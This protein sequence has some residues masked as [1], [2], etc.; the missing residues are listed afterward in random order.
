MPSS[1]EVLPTAK[2]SASTKVVYIISIF[3][4]L[5]AAILVVFGFMNLLSNDRQ[6]QSLD[7]QLEQTNR[8]V[9]QVKDLTQQNKELNQ[10][11]VNYAYCNALITA[12]HTRTGNPIQVEDLNRCI[13]KS[14]P[15][16]EG[17][18]TT[19]QLNQARLQQ[20][21]STNQNSSG[22][23]TTP[24]NPTKTTDPPNT[25]SPLIQTSPLTIP[26]TQVTLPCVNA[27]GVTVSCS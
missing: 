8:L 16:G 3:A 21:N 24:N 15:N 14:F 18:P 2:P 25:T 19:A 22:G 9:G 12:E 20:N 10:K 27:L 13:I 17:A 23:T 11:S 6:Q 7:E 5:A 4:I 26:S 1:P